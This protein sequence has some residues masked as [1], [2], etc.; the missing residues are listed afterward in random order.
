MRYNELDLKG[1]REKCDIDFA[2]YTYKNGMCSCCYGPK[3]LPAIYW[4]NR[5]IPTGDNYEYILFKNANNGSGVVKGTDEIKD[6]QCIEWRMAPEKLDK[7]CE[8]LK[9]QL[10][11]FYKVFKPK[12]YLFCIVVSQKGS[13]YFD[14]YLANENYSL[15][16]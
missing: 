10:G 1:L 9:K 14:E 12:D 3:D 13:R 15:V 7:V 8:E 4:R 5:I 6:Y 2:H 11:D 16:E